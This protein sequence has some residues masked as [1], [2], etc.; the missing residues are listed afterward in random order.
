MDLDSLTVREVAPTERLQQVY[1]P[2]FSPDGARVVYSRWGEGGYRDLYLRDV[3]TG[4]ERRLTVDRAMN[5][6]PCWS[7]DGAHVVFSSDRSGVFN[8]YAIHLDSGEVRQV[9]NVL[10]GAFE[11]AVSHDGETLAYVGFTASGYDLWTMPFDPDAWTEPLPATMAYPAAP[12]LDEAFVDAA[13]DGPDAA[14]EPDGPDDAA[15]A[16]GPD[17]ADGAS[18]GEGARKE[19]R[20]GGEVGTRRRYQPWRTFYP[21]VIMPT[22]FEFSS[23]DFLTDIG[24]STQ[25][26]DVVGLHSLAGTFRWLVD[27]QRP[28]GSVQW[29]WRRPFP[30]FS[31]SFGRTF[32][33]RGAATVFLR[34]R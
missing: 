15:G 26:S 33:E 29:V 11:C 8:L 18:A 19:R 2:R 9:T 20:G 6:S 7:A 17:G 23:S 14:S 10:G 32:R 34:R 28:A 24:I 31:A 21:R 22:A 5:Q 30:T 4:D 27:Y 12:R 25:L 13:T 16:D 1:T 3:A